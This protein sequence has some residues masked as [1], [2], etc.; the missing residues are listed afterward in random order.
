MLAH[1]IRRDDYTTFILILVIVGVSLAGAW[2]LNEIDNAITD[3]E[4]NNFL[5]AEFLI[6]IG[7]SI[8]TENRQP[9]FTARNNLR[10]YNQGNRSSCP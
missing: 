3:M 1:L 2:G 8:E 9:V 4:C 5:E 7:D 6:A 10:E